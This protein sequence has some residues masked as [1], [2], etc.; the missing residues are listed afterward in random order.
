MCLCTYL[1]L[2]YADFSYGQISKT[3]L[4]FDHINN[5]MADYAH[6]I[7]TCSPNMILNM[8]NPLLI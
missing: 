6:N 5:Q 7:T 1:L 2:M 8:E 4:V 3:A